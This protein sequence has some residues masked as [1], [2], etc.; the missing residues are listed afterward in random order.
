MLRLKLTISNRFEL[1]PTEYTRID[2]YSAF[3]QNIKPKKRYYNVNNSTENFVGGWGLFTVY[4][5]RKMDLSDCVD[6]AITTINVRQGGEFFD[7]QGMDAMNRI[8]R[9]YVCQN[10]R[11]LATLSQPRPF[12]YLGGKKREL[13]SY[14][15][16]DNIDDL[17]KTVHFELT[18]SD[19]VSM[20]LNG[21]VGQYIYLEFNIY[22]DDK[23]E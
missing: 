8:G 19:H 18:W 7:I 22:D 6:N 11:Y 13:P 17:K 4:C 10:R 5:R 15:L 16:V 2:R 1:V 9:Y 21:N 14:L 23:D 3:P 20:F 12:L